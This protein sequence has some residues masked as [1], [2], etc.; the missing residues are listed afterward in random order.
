MPAKKTTGNK[1]PPKT[2]T[3]K[4]DDGPDVGERGE[5]RPARY[6]TKRGNVREDR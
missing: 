3:D 5:Y 1:M 2:T 4:L 6:Q